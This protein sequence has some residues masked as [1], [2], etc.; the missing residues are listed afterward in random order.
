M[1]PD[2]R[3][4]RND[5]RFLLCCSDRFVCILCKATPLSSAA[6][7]NPRLGVWRP[8]DMSVRLPAARL[9]LYGR[10]ALVSLRLRDGRTEMWPLD[11]SF[12]KS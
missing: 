8:V 5:K 2:R 9:L 12:V 7:S 3:G 11:R 4:R 6:K 1:V 10:R